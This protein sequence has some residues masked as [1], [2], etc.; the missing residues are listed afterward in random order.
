MKICTVDE[1]QMSSLWK[2]SM[3]S[4]SHFNHFTSKLFAEITLVNRRTVSPTPWSGS[5]YANNA[6]TPS[7][8]FSHPSRNFEKGEN[9]LIVS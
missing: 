5:Y 4:C 3:L 1:M 9:F 7:D 8:S 6:H 2:G